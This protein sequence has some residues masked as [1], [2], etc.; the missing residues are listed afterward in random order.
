MKIYNQ[1]AYKG[2][3]FGT[4]K[5]SDMADFGCKLFCFASMYGIDPVEMDKIFC[6]KGVYS[7]AAGDLID[8]T[9]AAQALGWQFLGRETDINKMP[10]WEP[11]IKEV[12]FSAAPG[13]KQHFVVRMKE[14]ILDP[15][16]GV[17]RKKNYYEE[18]SGNFCSYRLFKVSETSGQPTPDPVIDH[19][20]ETI[21]ALQKENGELRT[22]LDSAHKKIQE[23]IKILS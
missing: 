10:D 9:K 12:D 7:G 21:E 5:Q 13:K 6:D 17:E 15:Y 8:D 23:A 20:N 22:A 19:A 3:K 2:I 18:K 4:K 16:G 11:T 14:S 1:L